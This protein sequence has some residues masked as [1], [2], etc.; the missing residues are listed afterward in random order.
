MLGTA[1]FSPP[2]GY[3]GVFTPPNPAGGHQGGCA[4]FIRSDVP[5]AGLPIQSSLQ[6]IA[7]TV[8]DKRRYTLC[9]I[10]L[11]P[12]AAVSRADLDGLLRQL[13]RP[14]LI[15]GDLNARHLLWGDVLSDPRGNLLASVVEDADLCVLNSGEPTHL[16]TQT[17]TLSVIDLSLSSPDCALDFIWNVCSDPRGS[18]HYPV[19]LST[20][21]VT[22]MPRLPRWR[23]D[24][25][26]WELFNDFIDFT[27][28]LS[29]FN[30]ADE[31]VEYFTSTL[32]RAAV[33]SI[34][35]SSG[36]FSRRP[37]PWWTD[38]CAAARKEYRSAYSRFR[39]RRN[40]EFLKVQYKRARAKYRLNLKNARRKS[41]RDYVSSINSSTPIS[42][43]WKRI[44]KI[45]IQS[46]INQQE[47]ITLMWE[48]I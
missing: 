20:P 38:D 43:V 39:A 13:P 27:S 42:Q 22:P 34:P 6:A 46:C 47:K 4:T 7:V 28:L 5:F 40:S 23:L 31:A 16:H 32:Y 35:Q 12:S 24:V 33:R 21:D 36:I 25:A 15:V 29:D 45:L 41:W 11:P 37:V 10:Y 48:M 17:G 14:F 44:Q 2:R 8:Y 1:V 3:T 9:N 18:D 26:D 30:T 19:I